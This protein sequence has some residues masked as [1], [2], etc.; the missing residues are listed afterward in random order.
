MT[1]TPYS[2]F[3]SSAYHPQPSQSECH[4]KAQRD[5]VTN[6]QQRSKIS[7]WIIHHI[8]TISSVFACYLCGL[9]AKPCPGH[10]NSIFCQTPLDS[11]FLFLFLR[12]YEYVSMARTQNAWGGLHHLSS[13][14]RRVLM[15]LLGTMCDARQTCSWVSVTKLNFWRRPCDGGSQ[16]GRL[17]PWC[18][19]CA[20]ALGRP[21]LT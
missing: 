12:L 2:H 11:F 18:S 13:W 1:T 17:R 16:T 14:G 15:G 9:M 21:W 7:L 4:S 19:P 5:N 3:L 6:L 10:D 20:P 8:R